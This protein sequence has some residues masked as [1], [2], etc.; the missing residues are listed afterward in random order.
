MLQFLSRRW[1]GVTGWGYL[2]SLGV[3]TGLYCMLP[4]SHTAAH[5][6]S[7]DGTIR[8]EGFTRDHRN[9][10]ITNQRPDRTVFHHI[11]I[12]TGVCTTY[13]PLRHPDHEIDFQSLMKERCS[14]KYVEHGLNFLLDQPRGNHGLPTLV[15]VKPDGSEQTFYCDVGILGSG[16]INGSTSQGFTF[17]WKSDFACGLASID[18]NER[19]LIATRRFSEA[20]QPVLQWVQKTFAWKPSYLGDGYRYSAAIIDVVTSQEIACPLQAHNEPHYAMH[21]EA[22]GFAVLDVREIGVNATTGGSMSSTLT[23]YHLPLGPTH[24]SLQQWY[25]ILAAFVVPVVVLML[26]NVFGRKRSMPVCVP[27]QP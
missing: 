12:E 3:A 26:W 6:W 21:P 9:L 16:R 17:L 22:L 13:L 25:F 20:W 27:P 2:L 8:F 23:W 24:H 18:G 14:L 1:W 7:F 15:L 10:V 11:Q 4:M 5:I 19:W